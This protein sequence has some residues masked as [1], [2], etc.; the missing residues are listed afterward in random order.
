MI[1]NSVEEVHNHAKKA[2]GKTVFELNGNKTVSGSKSTVG[3]AFE[4][5]F[6]KKPDSSR[7]PDL[8][9]VGVE[10]KATPFHKLKKGQYSAKERLVFNIINYEEI[11]SETFEESHFLYKNKLLAIGFYEYLKEVPQDEWT[12][13]ETILFEMAKNPKDFE[14]IKDDWNTIQQYVNS[15]RAHELSESLTNYLSACTKGASSKSVR[16]QPYSDIPAKQRAFSF[17]AGYM[18]SLLRKYVLGDHKIE[19]IIK[20]PFELIEKDIETIVLERFKPYFNWTIEQLKTYFGIQGNS[21]QNNYRIAAAILNLDGKYGDTEAFHNVEEFEK[22]SIVLKTVKFNENNVNPESM[23][24]PSFRFEDLSNESWFNEKGEPSATWHNFLADTRF[25]LFVVKSENGQDVFKGVKFFAVPDQDLQGPIRYVWED[26]LKKIN[27]GIELTAVQQRNGKI[28][29]KNN[30]IEKS[31]NLI[32]HVRPHETKRDY[33]INGKYA[34]KLPAPIKWKNRP[35]GDEFSDQW[36][37]KQC[38]WLNNDY[39]KKQV[40]DLL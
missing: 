21:Y 37:T 31:D 27:E 36:I 20:D 40:A 4:N 17:K 35:E 32:S 16:K 18:T 28:I 25:L 2:I 12:I 23:S 22:A 9:E 1:F 7:G 34:D 14:I 19:S 38:F 8:P 5:W 33:S 26:T 15:G 30:F 39:I 24:F 11:A 13:S 29:I 10:L 3:D 6:G